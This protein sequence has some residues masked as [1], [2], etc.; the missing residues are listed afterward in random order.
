MA[1]K[2]ITIYTDGA[3][4]GNPGP[5]GYGI[6][7][8]YGPH[9]KDLSEGYRLTTNN[10]MELLAVIKALESVKNPEIEIDLFTDSKYVVDAISKGWLN[11]W[12]NTNFKGG[13]K[14][15]DLWKRYY[16]LSKKFKIKF[17]WV[18]GH[19]E[20]IYNNRCDQLATEAADGTK[21]KV[22]TQYELMNGEDNSLL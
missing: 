16:Q 8:M 14:N 2:K 10:R 17:H 18:K 4:R 1:E 9:R 22:D 21:L 20:N 3:A 7:M 12:I 5:G 6:V 15:V 19:A 13:K 11:K